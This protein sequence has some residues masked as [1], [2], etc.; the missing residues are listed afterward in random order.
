MAKKKGIEAKAMMQA[1]PSP[2]LEDNDYETEGHLRTMMEAH[3]IMGDPEKM[4]KV[5]KLAGRHAKAIRS[6]QDIH[7]HYNSKY[8][9]KNAMKEG[10]PEE[11]ASET[12]EEEAAEQ[13]E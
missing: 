5:H 7:D 11:E 8:G 2:K 1:L 6:I 13:G 3:K 12:P 4:K 10:S 9:G